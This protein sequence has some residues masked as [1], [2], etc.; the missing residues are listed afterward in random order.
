M[1]G[2]AEVWRDE[3]WARKATRSS[4]YTSVEIYQKIFRAEVGVYDAES[5]GTG[6]TKEFIAQL[7]FEEAFLGISLTVQVRCVDVCDKCGGSRSELGYAVNI[8]PY[9]EGMGEETVRTGHITAR[10][11]SSYC[12]GKDK[13]NECEGRGRNMFNWPSRCCGVSVDGK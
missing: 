5:P 7:S 11:T 9:C 10:K 1:A 13:Y 12:E 3:Q 2:G 6:S 8:C 4:T